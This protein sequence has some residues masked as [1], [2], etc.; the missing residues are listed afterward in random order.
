MTSTIKQLYNSKNLSDDTLL[1][2][3][4]SERN[5]F[6][7]DNGEVTELFIAAHRYNQIAFSRNA[8]IIRN[9]RIPE[10]APT[11]VAIPAKTESSEHPETRKEWR[12]FSNHTIRAYP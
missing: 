8:P 10:L 1:S 6:I 5:L 9:P 12:Y 4:T 2:L 11:R 7:Q 3:N